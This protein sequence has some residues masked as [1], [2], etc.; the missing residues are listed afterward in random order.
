MKARGEGCSLDANA[1]PGFIFGVWVLRNEGFGGFVSMIVNHG[2]YRDLPH[3][4]LKIWVDDG[5]HKR[6]KVRWSESRRSLWVR[7]ELLTN[8]L[9]KKRALCVS[10]EKQGKCKYGER[11]RY[12]HEST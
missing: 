6:A 11:C 9:P 7:L 12:L 10:F 8:R 5:M 3:L 2:G 4:H 1:S